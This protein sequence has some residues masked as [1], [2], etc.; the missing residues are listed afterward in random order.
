V[1]PRVLGRKLASPARIGVR[2]S[3]RATSLAHHPEAAFPSWRMAMAQNRTVRIISLLVGCSAAALMQLVG[4]PPWYVSV[5]FGVLAY[6]VARLVCWALDKRRATKYEL[7]EM[8][9][10]I[11]RGER[12]KF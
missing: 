9:E 10:A 11:D 2:H 7:D 3:V 8:L 5:P 6:F 1:C 4:S 12:P